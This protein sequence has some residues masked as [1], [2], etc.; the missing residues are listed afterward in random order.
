MQCKR[1]HTPTGSPYVLVATSLQLYKSPFLSAGFYRG[2]CMQRNMSFHL[3][4]QY[5]KAYYGWLYNTLQKVHHLHIDDLYTDLRD[6]K[7]LLQ[8]LETVSGEKIPYRSRKSMRGSE[9]F[10]ELDRIQLALDF[11]RKQNVSSEVVILQITSSQL[12]IS[13]GQ[14]RVYKSRKAAPSIFSSLKTY[15]STVRNANTQ[16]VMGCRM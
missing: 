8:L 14:S 10:E 11:L 3:V 5:A 2:R 4:H 13:R 12:A 7:L 6:G 15:I 16:Y 1:K 9:M